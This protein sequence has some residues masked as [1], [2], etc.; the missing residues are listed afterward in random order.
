[1]VKSLKVNSRLFKS[2]KLALK[3]NLFLNAEAL[4]KLPHRKRMGHSIKFVSTQGQGI[5][6]NGLSPCD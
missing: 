6:P 2:V 5:K 1:M 4:S 3:Q